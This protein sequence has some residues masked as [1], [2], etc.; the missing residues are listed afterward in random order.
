MADE[1]NRGDDV[2]GTLMKRQ[3]MEMKRELETPLPFY[4]GEATPALLVEGATLAPLSRGG[5]M[6]EELVAAFSDL[7]EEKAVRLVTERLEAG[8]DPM[9]ILAG[10]QEGMMQV[11]KRFEKSEYFIS[12]L[13]MAGEIFKAATAPLE[14]RIATAGGSGT[15]GKIVFG[16]VK[17]DIHNIGKDIVVGLLR[18][19]G[20]EVID[21]GIDVPSEKFVE[22]VKQTGARIVGLSGLLTVAYGSMKE[23]IRAL[24]G[25]GLKVR[26]MIGGGPMTSA[27]KEHVGAD[28]FG[29]DAQAAVRFANQW[30]EELAEEQNITGGHNNETCNC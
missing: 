7:E 19:G 24:D 12:D 9:T 29:T 20:F 27:V 22:A 25:A 4:E 17:G 13:M 5:I 30:T 14:A 1:R 15:R 26:V 21:L 16:T 23:T 18:A 28:A 6:N 8:D 3:G 10:C 2:V 11:G